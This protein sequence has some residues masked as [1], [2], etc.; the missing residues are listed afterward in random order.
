M[1]AFVSNKQTNKR[2][3]LNYYVVS[4]Y[5]AINEVVFTILAQYLQKR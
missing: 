5:I 4:R 1:K 3:R 2:K